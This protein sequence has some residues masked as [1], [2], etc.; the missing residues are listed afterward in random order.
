MCKTTYIHPKGNIRH[1]MEPATSVE[2]AG[3]WGVGAGTGAGVTGAADGSG[4][5]G[6]CVGARVGVWVGVGVVGAGVGDGVG[7]AVGVGVVGTG[8]RRMKPLTAS[9]SEGG[10]ST[11]SICRS[12]VR[13]AQYNKPIRRRG[14]QG[15]LMEKR[16]W[17]R[18]YQMHHTIA[19]HHIRRR[20]SRRAIELHFV[21]KHAPFDRLALESG[22]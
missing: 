2:E 16:K 1:V 10:T 21:S 4:V 15:H 9:R 6:S 13:I 12:P 18:A 19:R 3:G 17:H 14:S 22:R 5:T 11:P 8:V 20:H 7:A